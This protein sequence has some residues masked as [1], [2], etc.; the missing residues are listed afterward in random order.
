MTAEIM[1]ADEQD[2]IELNEILWDYDMG[3]PG[4]AEEMLVFKKEG[5][6]LGGAKIVEVEENRFFLEVLGVKQ[7]QHS[8]GIGRILLSEILQNPWECCKYPLSKFQLK[9]PY[10]I[11]TMARGSAVGF[12]KKMGFKNCDSLL[13]PQEYSEQCDFCP[14]KGECD[15]SPMIFTG[16]I[17]A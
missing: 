6:T 17:K 15:P 9:K 13:L 12:Y 7:A 5:Q 16:G 14:D 10:T 8:Q 11:T 4:Q 3:I 2:E 1:F